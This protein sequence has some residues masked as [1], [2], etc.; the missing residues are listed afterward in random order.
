M[1]AGSSSERPASTPGPTT[2]AKATR[3]VC[4]R[5]ASANVC[6][7]VLALGLFLHPL[8][9]GVVVGEFVQVGERDL[10]RHDR[11]VISHVRSRIMETMLQFDIHAFP[12]LLEIEGR[13]VPIDP[14]L[15]AHSPGLV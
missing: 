7:T 12:E 9:P 5:A 1:P 11:I 2:A 13:R 3:R 6:R 4:R 15:G 8:E 14:D 10:A